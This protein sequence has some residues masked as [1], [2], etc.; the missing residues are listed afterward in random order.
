MKQKKNRSYDDK[1]AE[2]YLLLSIQYYKQTSSKYF[3]IYL[4]VSEFSYVQSEFP[5]QSDLSTEQVMFDATTI[6]NQI[7]C[8]LSNSQIHKEVQ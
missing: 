4:R 3:I 5:K 2:N 7:A 6:G 8:L 1:A